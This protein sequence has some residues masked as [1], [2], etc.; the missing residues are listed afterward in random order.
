MTMQPEQSNIDPTLA[1]F[2]RPE[3]Q[4][5]FDRVRQIKDPVKLRILQQL[6]DGEWHNE[7]ELVRLAKKFRYM[8]SVGLGI[9]FEQIRRVVNDEFVEQEGVPKMP[10]YK[11]F[12]IKENYVGLTRAAFH[13]FAR[14]QRSRDLRRSLDR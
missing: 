7:T 11:R 1:P 3:Y 6:L 10:T 14:S 9:L 8:G 5:L 2:F 4:V 13:T 12:K